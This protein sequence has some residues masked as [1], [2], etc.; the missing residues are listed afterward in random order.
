MVVFIKQV[1]GHQYGR[2]RPLSASALTSFERFTRRALHPHPN[3]ALPIQL[4]AQW[5]RL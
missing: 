3:F 1:L 4:R 2:G 5:D